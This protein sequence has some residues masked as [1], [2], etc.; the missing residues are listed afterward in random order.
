M[1]C[2]FFRLQRGPCRLTMKNNISSGFLFTLLLFV[3][4]IA[5]AHLVSTRFG[6]FYSGLLHPVIT[7]SHLLPW[8]ALGLMC[9]LQPT[10]SARKAPLL[11]PLAVAA[12]VMLGSGLP[13]L[14]MIEWLNR[15]STLLLGILVVLASKLPKQTFN[16][17][18]VL[19]GLCHGYANGLLELEGQD[20][21]LYVAGVLFAAYVLVTLTA[22]A[23]QW[24][25]QGQRWGI[26][27]IRALGSW[28]TA[29]GVLYF[30]YSMLAPAT[31]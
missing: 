8:L 7:F 3:P 11:F 4:Q 22:A 9:G 12:G 31:A 23:S 15:V 19:V 21:A 10:E 16:V 13:Q 27:A 24:L 28:V 26:I 17:L 18:V 5:Q 14:E 25:V 1:W 29:I 20:L 6:E 30:G 2:V